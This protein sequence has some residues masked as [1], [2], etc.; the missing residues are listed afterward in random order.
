VAGCQ[1][2]DS[3]LGVQS[4]GESLDLKAD[5]SILAGEGLSWG[6]ELLFH[7]MV[8]GFASWAPAS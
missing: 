8:D 3:V 6:W 1:K 7:Q 4:K 2:L 5:R